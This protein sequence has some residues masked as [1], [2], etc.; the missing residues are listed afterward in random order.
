M[1]TPGYSE[2]DALRASKRTLI[3][4]GWVEGARIESAIERPDRHGDD[5]TELV[6]RV[7]DG[8]GGERTIKIWLT[9]VARGA[10]LL[11]HTC[12]AVGAL[13][14]YE[15]GEISPDLFPGHVVA[16]KIGVRK[17][18]GFPDQNIIEDVRAAAGVVNLRRVG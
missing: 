2:S 13:A 12:E 3:K 1:K 4:L 17:Q 11:R 15:A 9:S 18:R 10:A 14:Q 5:M 6:V 16:V 8:N 7:P